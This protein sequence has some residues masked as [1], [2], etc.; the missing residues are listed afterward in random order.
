MAR[1]PFDADDQATWPITLLVDEVAAIMRRSAK[2]IHHA[3][4]AGVFVPLPFEEKPYR[5]RREDIEAWR[6]GEYRDAAA[7]LR[8]KRRRAA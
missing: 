4:A 5:W 2:G 8:A 7:A 3:L 6:A 1:R